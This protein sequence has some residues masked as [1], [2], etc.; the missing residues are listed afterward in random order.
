MY[1]VATVSS[2]L[3]MKLKMSMWEMD[4]LMKPR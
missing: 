3:R 2:M 1:I 4:M